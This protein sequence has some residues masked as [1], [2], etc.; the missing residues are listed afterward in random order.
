MNNTFEFH[1][2]PGA[3]KVMRSIHKAFVGAKKYNPAINYV[4]QDGRGNT[5]GFREA[6]T[7]YR[8]FLGFYSPGCPV[9]PLS[10]L[11]QWSHINP[12][13]RIY[14]APPDDQYVISDN[15]LP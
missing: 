3:S 13:R 12:I 5:F 14:P 11:V 2:C 9:H 15:R 10:N 4:A 1:G 6:P 8:E 7:F